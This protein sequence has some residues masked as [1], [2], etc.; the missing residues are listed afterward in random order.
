MLNKEEE[1]VKED[2]LVKPKSNSKPRWFWQ[3]KVAPPLK[4][5][6]LEVPP[7]GSHLQE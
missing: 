5:P 6:L 3:N 1:Q 2:E 7:Q 4:A